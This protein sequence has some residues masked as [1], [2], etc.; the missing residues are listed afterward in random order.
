MDDDHKDV[1]DDDDDDIDVLI[2]NDLHAAMGSHE[3]H[4]SIDDLPDDLKPDALQTK[5]MYEDPF[6]DTQ[7]QINSI[8]TNIS[9][10]DL[11]QWTKTHM[12]H[13]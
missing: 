1:D 11:Q 9:D 6:T 10:C 8:L 13:L 7:K 3:S 4:V 5:L 2:P 12:D